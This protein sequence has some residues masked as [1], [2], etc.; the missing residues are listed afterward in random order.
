MKHID[1]R[2]TVLL[3]LSFLLLL[4]AFSCGKE[5][6]GENPAAGTEPDEETL[7]ETDPPAPP[8]T[9]GQNGC[10]FIL[11]IPE[12]RDIK[13]LQF[14]D[15][16]TVDLKQARNSV[17]LGDLTAVYY[18]S[19]K[20]DSE[21]LCY[22][23]MD[24]AVEKCEP[25]LIVLTGDIIYGEADD[26]GTLWMEMCDRLDSYGIP[27][28]A[29]FGNHDNESAMGVLW[30]IEYLTA[31][32]H[33]LFRQGDVTGNSNYNIVVRQ[34]GEAKYLLYFL[35]SNG[36]RQI[37]HPGEGI[38]AD[39]PDL[40]LIQQKAGIYPDQIDW[41]TESAEKIFASAGKR[42]PVMSFFHI[43][44]KALENAFTE[45]Y[46]IDVSKE[47]HVEFDD[48][49][50]FGGVLEYSVKIDRDMAFFDA[51]QSIGTVGMF[52]GHEHVNDASVV[53]E[54]IRLT[55]GLKTGTHTYWRS[56]HVG[57][58]QITLSETDGGFEVTHL[59]SDIKN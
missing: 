4:F 37:D 54:G 56:G 39:N 46:G 14:T 41:M 38:Q 58:T 31:C 28:A 22:Q 35:D 23:F 20:C 43:P 6:P 49:S 42:L 15:T 27:W 44:P 24:E 3:L 8:L 53:Y 59:F 1:I 36:C 25:D 12:G 48:D 2:R 10:D 30:Q 17:R 34:G 52:F 32:Q 47:K 18:G 9:A 40:D 13:I 33:S 50:D 29:V 26:N 57:G 7:P 55:F 51:A 45:Y 21:T 5:D 19:R 16:Q 11:D